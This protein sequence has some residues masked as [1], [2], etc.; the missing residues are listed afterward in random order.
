M[1]EKKCWVVLPSGCREVVVLLLEEVIVGDSVC[2]NTTNCGRAQSL[3]GEIRVAEA[4]GKYQCGDQNIRYF[5]LRNKGHLASCMTS[6]M[7]T[8][9]SL[10]RKEKTAR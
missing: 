3:V 7:K 5:L 4:Q 8:E 10:E 1:S 9:E 6:L 2:Q